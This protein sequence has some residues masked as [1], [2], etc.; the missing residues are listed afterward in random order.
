MVN[1]FCDSTPKRCI[2]Q[3]NQEEK[4]ISKS[5]RNNHV[6]RSSSINAA[7]GGLSQH[8]VRE[9]FPFLGTSQE[10]NPDPIVILRI[11]TEWSHLLRQT[12]TVPLLVIREDLRVGARSAENISSKCDDRDKQRA[13]KGQKLVL[14]MLISCFCGRYRCLLVPDPGSNGGTRKRKRTKGR[15]LGC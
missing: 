8:Y 3:K 4:Q 5:N 7:A 10:R 6:Q 12:Q 15:W 13:I 9:H 14:V 1:S 2:Q 11:I